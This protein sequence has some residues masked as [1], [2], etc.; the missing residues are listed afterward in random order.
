[1]ALHADFEDMM[2]NIYFLVQPDEELFIKIVDIFL[3]MFISTESMINMI[4][5]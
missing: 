2:Y 3:L 5:L 4:G 1:M